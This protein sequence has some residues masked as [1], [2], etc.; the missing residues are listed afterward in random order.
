VIGVVEDVRY[1][2]LA[3][4]AGGAMYM[5]WNQLPLGVVSLV[6]RSSGDPRSLLGGI[7]STLQQM[8]PTM[9]IEAPRLVGE[10]ASGSIAERRLQVEVGAA[11]ALLTL[12]L[13]AC[14][15]VASLLRLVD[16]RRHELAIRAALGG[17]PGQLRGLILGFGTRLAAAGLAIGAGGAFATT[18]VLRQ[19]LYAVAPT[20]PATFV[21]VTGVVLVICV[22]ACVVPAIRASRADP[23]SLLR[24]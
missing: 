11:F 8:D 22:G 3:V 10:L 18:R 20:D 5:P 24:A 1:N 6:V 2:G 19:A 12:A 4:T 17:S 9:A 23:A 14:G 13:A 15:L 7:R 21:A 16:E